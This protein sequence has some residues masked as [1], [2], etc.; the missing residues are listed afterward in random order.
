MRQYSAALAVVC[1][2]L[3]ASAPAEANL[4]TNA[5]FEDQQYSTGF[6]SYANGVEAPWTNSVGGGVL[7]ASGG[8]AW[9]FGSGPQGF[10]GDQYAFLQSYGTLSQTFTS[11]SG[12]FDLSFLDAGRSGFGPYNGDQTFDVLIDNVVV[13]SFSTVSNSNFAMESILNIVL[14]SGVHTLEFLGTDLNGGDET[15]F[16]DNVIRTQVPEPS[17]VALLGTFLLGAWGLFRLRK[18]HVS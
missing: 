14:T 18:S 7:N 1:L 16:I 2:A 3:M 13:G 9:Y 12:L 4:L 11:G 6:Y 17:T 8:S 5:S 15:A 10:D